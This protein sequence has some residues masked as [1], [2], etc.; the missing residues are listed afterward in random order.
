MMVVDSPA[1]QG[2]PATSAATAFKAKLCQPRSVMSLQVS[3]M[4][5]DLRN[6]AVPTAKPVEPLKSSPTSVFVAG[7]AI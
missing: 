1:A 2:F 4:S 3:P 5:V 6:C 7:L